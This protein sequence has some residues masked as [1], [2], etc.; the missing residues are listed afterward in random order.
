MSS[1]LVSLWVTGEQIA[2]ECIYL[3]QQDELRMV[4]VGVGDIHTGVHTTF[5]ISGRERLII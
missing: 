5:A 4:V 1:V 3:L 2:V